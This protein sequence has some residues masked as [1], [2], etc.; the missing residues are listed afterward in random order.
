LRAIT[1]RKNTR[2][3]CVL[4]PTYERAF[5]GMLMGESDL[6]LVANAYEGAFRFHQSP[7]AFLLLAFVQEQ[8]REP[9]KKKPPH[10]PRTSW[11][12]FAP[13]KI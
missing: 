11:S 10:A 9:S 12:L 4:C 7:R 8:P 6:F 5:A 3:E 13:L 1:P 2:S